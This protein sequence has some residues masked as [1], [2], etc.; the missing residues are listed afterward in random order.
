MMWLRQVLRTLIYLPLRPYI[1]K[2]L[3]RFLRLTGWLKTTTGCSSDTHNILIIQ[4]YSSLGD[5]VLTFPLLDEVHRQWPEAAIDLVVGTPMVSLYR[6]IPFVR[7]V[8]GYSRSQSKPPIALYMDTL[9]LLLLYRSKI[10]SCYDL[11]LDPWWN[12][13]CHA[14]LARAMAFISGASVRASYSG[15]VGGIDTSLGSDKFMTHLA[16]GGLSEQ[17]SIRKLR[18]LQRAGLSTRTVEES[19]AFKV[20]TTL[21]AL[22]DSGIPTIKPLLF[23][24]NI[25]PSE[26]YGVLAPSASTPA[27]IWPIEY[28]LEVIQ[29][30][31][32]KHGMR[33]IV[34]GSSK[35]LEICSNFV[36]MCA[37][38]AVSLAGKTNV[39]ELLA[40]LRNARIFIGNDS[41]PAHLSGMIGCP[42][43]MN[44]ISRTSTEELDHITAPRRF[45]PCGPHVRLVTPKNPLHPCGPICYREEAHC[46]TQISPID[47]L[48]ACDDLMS[49]DKSAN[50]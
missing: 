33:F 23:E 43:I 10:S 19:E 44:I 5:L 13:D 21:A 42:T 41:G 38:S 8:Y 36:T 4:P 47:V 16:M 49:L 24:A 9:S 32:S 1:L 45:R 6:E 34:V 35:E 37:G 40:L 26:S 2:S 39:I 3:V 27:K 14:Y 12:P 29:T 22:A 30:L 28:L 48:A 15:D 25:Q 50:F 46:I 11:A 20:N 7:H 31:H 18:L 17:E